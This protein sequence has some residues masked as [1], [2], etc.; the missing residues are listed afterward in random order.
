MLKLRTFATFAAAGLL[1]V[2][3]LGQAALAAYAIPES[4]MGTGTIGTV[5][6]AART[7]TVNGHTYPISSKAFVTGAKSFENLQ[8]GMRVRYIM[9]GPVNKTSSVITHII[10][11]PALPAQS[12]GHP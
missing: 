5:N 3:L 12:G 1:M 10:V 2:L 11:L 7:L 8:T 9:N 4:R 6:Y